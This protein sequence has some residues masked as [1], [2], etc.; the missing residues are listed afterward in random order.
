MYLTHTLSLVSG[1]LTMG[2]K[3][4][5]TSNQELKTKL[6]AEEKLLLSIQGKVNA[7][8]CILTLILV[9]KTVDNACSECFA[10]FWKLQKEIEKNVGKW[11]KGE[12][13]PEPEIEL[14]PEA[15][16]AYRTEITWYLYKIGQG[17]GDLKA[18][19]DR[20]GKQANTV[21]KLKEELK[22]AGG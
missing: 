21:E 22:K 17:K 16:G 19:Q 3:E 11:V 9:I 15:A 2:G 10:N 4:T 18:M 7:L 8:V 5:M 12:P 20:L 1:W 14:D 6:A 13:F